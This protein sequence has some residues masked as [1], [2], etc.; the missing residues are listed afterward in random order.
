MTNAIKTAMMSIHGHGSPPSAPFSSWLVVTGETAVVVVPESAEGSVVATAAVVDVAC[1]VV[2]VLVAEVV[3]GGCLSSRCAGSK[4][5]QE[6]GRE[7]DRSR[8]CPRTVTAL[9]QVVRLK[10]VSIDLD[11]VVYLVTFGLEN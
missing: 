11:A 3:W 2:V 7:R 6:A 8:P 10:R 1:W 4:E 5:I 9:V